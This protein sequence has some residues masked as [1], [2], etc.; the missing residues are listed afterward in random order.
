MPPFS[1]LRYPLNHLLPPV[2]LLYLQLVDC[3]SVVILHCTYVHTLTKGYMIFSS[4]Y[5]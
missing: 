5:K 1:H 2:L 3:T 4:R